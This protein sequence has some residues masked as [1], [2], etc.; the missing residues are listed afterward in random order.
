VTVGDDDGIVVFP[1]GLVR[2]RVC[3]GWSW[4]AGMGWRWVLDVVMS[5]LFVPGDAT[6]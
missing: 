1:V 6:I 2:R 5:C 3:G 4:Q